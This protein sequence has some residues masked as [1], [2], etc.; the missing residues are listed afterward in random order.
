MLVDTFITSTFQFTECEGAYLKL[1]VTLTIIFSRSRTG[2][3][4]TD[5]VL[6]RLIR[7]AIQTGFFIGIFS[8]GSLITFVLLPNTSLYAI[9]SIPLGRIYT[10]VSVV[11]MTKIYKLFTFLSSLEDPYG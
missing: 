8:L 9:F 1:L 3:R 6:D 2:I 5:A 7:G 11:N 10:N 4:K